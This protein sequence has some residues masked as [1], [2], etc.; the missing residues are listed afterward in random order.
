MAVTTPTLI[1]C[2]QLVTHLLAAWTGRGANDGVERKYGKRIGDVTDPNLKLV[3]RKVYLFPTHYDNGPDTRGEDNF[4][5]EIS[6]L[7]VER[8]EGVGDPPEAWTDTRVDFVYEQIVQGFDFARESPSWNLK[9]STLSA[10]VQ[11]CDVEKL[12]S[13]GK[14]FY[15]LTE[16]V[17]EELRNA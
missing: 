8:Y 14:L 1:L 12:F 15:S 7:V 3:G 13:S 9:L 2:D 16:L 17:F 10:N 4:I 5:H 6:A 11:V